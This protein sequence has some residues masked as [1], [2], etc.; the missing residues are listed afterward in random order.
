MG[1]SLPRPL[2][3]QLAWD[4]GGP[5]APACPRTGISVACLTSIRA[6]VR[7]RLRSWVR[8]EPSL[9][10]ASGDDVAREPSVDQMTTSVLPVAERYDR[11]SA[12]TAAPAT[13]IR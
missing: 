8:P 4:R 6:H 10:R 13:S 12:L 9:D 1:D 5:E 2:P 11:S 7:R 3:V